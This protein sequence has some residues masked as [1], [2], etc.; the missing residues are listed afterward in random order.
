MTKC[1]FC[2]EQVL[3]GH[4]IIF[5]DVAGKIFN[6][7]SS[8]CRKNMELGRKAEKLGWIRKKKK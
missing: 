2:G 4:G 6:F 3:P 8:K 5:V 7:C 1:S